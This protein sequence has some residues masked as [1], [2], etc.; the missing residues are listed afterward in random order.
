M[1]AALL[2]VKICHVPPPR[3]DGSKLPCNYSAERTESL[4]RFSTRSLQ[5]P[6][7]EQAFESGS[8]IRK[9]HAVLMSLSDEIE[10][11]TKKS[12]M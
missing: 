1:S 3:A 6:E 7:T 8:A 4:W 11:Q 12:S 9:K 5:P 2:C 10:K